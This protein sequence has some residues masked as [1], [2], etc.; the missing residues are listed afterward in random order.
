MRLGFDAT[1]LTPEGKGLARFQ[2]EVLTAAA[3]L[4]EPEELVIFVPEEPEEGA[5]PAVAGWQYVHVETRPM[6]R[7]EQ[8][9][10]PRA[11]KAL[12]LDVV[13]TL[14]E[15]AAL[16]GPPR[17]VYVF[18][19]PRLR[20]QRNREVGVGARQR[21]VDGVTLGLFFLAQR[22]AAAVLASSESTRR[23]LGRGTVVYPGVSREFSPGDARPRGYF[24]HIASH[25]PRDNTET[26]LAAHERCGVEASLVVG[27]S[28]RVEGPGVEFVGYRTGEALADLY[29]GAIAY[30]DP[31]LYEGFGLQALESLA[32]GTPVICSNVT[33]LPEVVGDAGMLLDPLDVDGFAAAMRRLAEDEALRDDLS[34]KAIAQ[35]GRF[36]WERTVRECVAACSEAVKPRMR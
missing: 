3:E 32:C 11:A 14:S 5:L 2:R 7:W 8:L 26:V 24:L 34:R 18:E 21:L 28:R 25:D 10:L 4:G 13:L 31:S 29:R 15:R 16:W 30:V 9:G 20:V 35:A 19:H 6:L 17:V 33:S 12:R 27:G 22:R 36:S 1:S 23:D